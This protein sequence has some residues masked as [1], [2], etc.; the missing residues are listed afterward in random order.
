MMNRRRVISGICLV[1]VAG[2][3][4][5]NALSMYGEPTFRGVVTEGFVMPLLMGSMIGGVLGIVQ[6][7]RRR[8]DRTALVGAALTLV[9]AAVGIR[10]RVLSQLSALGQLGVGG[11][12]AD[13]QH[14]LQRHAPLAWASIVPSGL[15]FPIGVITLGITIFAVHPVHRWIG[16][17][18]ATGGLLFPFGRAVHIPWAYAASDVLIAL[19]FGLLGWQVLTRPELWSGEL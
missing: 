12:P 2:F 18:L 5:W 17:V 9:G 10:I 8:A 3:L 13:F 1:S 16:I 11:L 19:A 4:V 14:V 7:L 15:L 6:L